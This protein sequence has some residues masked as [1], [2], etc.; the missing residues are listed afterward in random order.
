MKSRLCTMWCLTAS[1]QTQARSQSPESTWMPQHRM[2]TSVFSNWL[3]APSPSCRSAGTG[4]SRAYWSLMALSPPHRSA[5][6]SK[7]P[8]KSNVL[9]IRN[10]VRMIPSLKAWMQRQKCSADWCESSERHL[11]FGPFAGW[12][13]CAGP[14]QEWRARITVL[15]DDQ[16][17]ATVGDTSMKGNKTQ[18]NAEWLRGSWHVLLFNWCF[19]SMGRGFGVLGFWATHRTLLISRGWSS[20][21]WVTWTTTRW[22][23]LWQWTQIKLRSELGS[24]REG[25]S[26]RSRSRLPGCRCRRTSQSLLSKLGRT[27]RRRELRALKSGRGS[28]SQCKI[29]IQ[30]HR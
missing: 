26:R 27:S 24:M 2:D 17:E 10:A 30:R 16:E 20:S 5:A 6:A 22:T 4:S 11:R 28:T 21:Q 12:C 8:E 1:P 19:K 9:I 7:T 18:F 3:N 23:T 15:N 25:R 14:L 29:R 13:W